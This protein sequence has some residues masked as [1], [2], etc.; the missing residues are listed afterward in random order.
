MVKDPE[1][2]DDRNRGQGLLNCYYIHAQEFKEKHEH[3]EEKICNAIKYL[4]DGIKTLGDI[5]ETRSIYIFEYIAI[6]KIHNE[7]RKKKCSSI[8][9]E[10]S[11]SSS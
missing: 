4:L 9:L 7:L 2:T 10:I 11:N 3:N 8:Q 6:E 1:M 5:T